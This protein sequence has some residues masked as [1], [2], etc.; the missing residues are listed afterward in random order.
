M[1]GYTSIV[2]N[3]EDWANMITNVEMAETPFLD[4]L[5]V[6]DQP[7]NVL[8]NY[9]AEKYDDPV[10]NAH[11]DGKP[12]VGFQSAGDGRAGL[13]ALIQYF[14]KT[15]SVTRLHQDVSNIAGVEDELARDMVKRTKELARDIEVAFL[16]DNDHQEDTGSQ[17]Y[18]TRGVGSWVS[19]SAQTL[20]P[21]NSNF[22]PPS[23]SIST[24][25]SSSLTETVI[26]DIL[27]SMGGVTKSKTPITAFIG[28]KAKRAFNNIPLFTPGSVLVGG[29][30]TGASGVV[31]NK[32]GKTIDRVFERY[33]TD[34][35]P[36]DVPGI[37]WYNVFLTGSAT[38]RAYRTYFLH[39]NMWELR[40]GP[41]ANG[42]GAKSGK[43]TWFRKEYQGGAYEAFCETLAMLVCKNPKGEGKYAPTA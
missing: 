6:G 4:W 11:I 8:Y 40:W 1:L 26:L 30:P 27:E 9:Q 33:M 42:S 2:G 13:K 41:G 5:P 31:Y 18:K 36:V 20:Y 43:P 14:I 10:D 7:V 19:S 38:A 22:R 23:A 16:E 3:Q 29:S 28:Q 25:A 21:V 24:T 15:T 17:G 37:S 32:N 39:Q 34:F 35:G 12:V